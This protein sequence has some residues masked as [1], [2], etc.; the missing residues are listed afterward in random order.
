MTRPA[1]ERVVRSVLAALVVVAVLGS[2]RS[3]PIPSSR[4]PA[5][6]ASATSTASSHRRTARPVESRHGAS[7]G[8]SR[9]ALRSATCRREASIDSRTAISTTS[10]STS[11]RRRARRTLSTTSGFS[12][13]PQRVGLLLDAGV[14]E[15]NQNSS[16][17]FAP[18]GTEFLGTLPLGSTAY[19][20]GRAGETF[21]FNVASGWRAWQGGTL[22]AETPIL[23]SEGPRT[24]SP[25]ARLG[26]ERTFL[27]DAVGVEGRGTYTVIEDGVGAEGE[28]VPTQRQLL[29]VGVGT[30]ASRLGS[31]LREPSRGRRA[32]T[33]T[34]QHGH[35]ILG[36]DGSRLARLRDALRRRGARLLAHGHDRIPCSVRRCSPTTCA[37][38]RGCRSPATASSSSPRPTGY[39][40]GRLVDENAEL[41][42][43]VD[44][45]FFDAALGWQGD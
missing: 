6:R 5:R 9:R 16:L 3:Q 43:D 23:G 4:R 27:T 37:C 44:T 41:T 39:Q 2:R 42:A 11:P 20:L 32:P 38:A 31:R 33:R 18:P 22:V 45:V 26:I 34:P 36:A 10:C 28:P 15:S 1:A 40:H 35:R 29:M 13:S 24:F 12:T 19:L 7:S 17:T 8:C 14:V 21:T 25:G 30:L